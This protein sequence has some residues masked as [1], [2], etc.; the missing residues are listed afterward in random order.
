MCLC[1]SSAAVEAFANLLFNKL[2]KSSRVIKLKVHQQ[3]HF[4][5]DLLHC[6]KSCSFFY[7][8]FF[9]QQNREKFFANFLKF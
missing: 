6:Q 5:F 8:T 4:C 7:V 3:M 9:T 1:F 2:R